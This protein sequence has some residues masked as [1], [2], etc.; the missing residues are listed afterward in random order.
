VNS[1]PPEHPDLGE[2]SLAHARPAGPLGAWL[3]RRWMLLAYR[4]DEL[5]S[6]W[7]RGRNSLQLRGFM[8]TMRIIAKRLFPARRAPFPVLLYTDSEAAAEVR[9][10]EHPAAPRASIVIPV[11]GQLELTR[12]CLLSLAACG[13]QTS[14]E[15][16]VVDD[17]SPDASGEVLPA[18][19]GLRYLRNPQN[20]GLMG[21]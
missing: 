14:F 6:L 5:S 20:L 7:F 17:A 1:L 9:F 13:D 16:I 15:V 21:S 10:P 12:R 19:P 4:I 8:P 18:I 11:Y 3:S 2:D